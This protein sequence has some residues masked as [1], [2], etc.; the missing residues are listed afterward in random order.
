MR[1]VI[2]HIDPKLARIAN[3]RRE[4]G[5]QEKHPNSP[6]NVFGSKVV[7][8]ARK[9][10]KHRR[11]Y[12]RQPGGPLAAASRRK[13]AEPDQITVKPFSLRHL[14]QDWLH[15]H[16]SEYRGH[17]VA[18]EG[19]TLLAHGPSARQVLDA[20]RLQGYDRPLLV[21]IPSEPPLPFGGW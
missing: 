16:E 7:P 10:P 4:R 15:E 1:N 18:L 21:H 14:E 9:W 19:T 6:L 11:S 17:W 5:R 3:G 20:A 2:D 13:A 8:F 12:L